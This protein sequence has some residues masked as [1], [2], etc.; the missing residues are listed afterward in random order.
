MIISDSVFMKSRHP[1]LGFVCFFTV[2]SG[3]KFLSHFSQSMRNS[4]DS[5]NQR[6]L[7]IVLF[8]IMLRSIKFLFALS[9]PWHFT[10]MENEDKIESEQGQLARNMIACLRSLYVNSLKEILPFSHN[11]FDTKELLTFCV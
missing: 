10:I 7:Q 3:L 2:F 11:Y 9:T 8:I 5:T 6:F 4:L 1:C